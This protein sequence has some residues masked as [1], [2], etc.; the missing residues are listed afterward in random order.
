[1]KGKRR[2]RRRG[3]KGRKENLQSRKI[4]LVE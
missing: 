3:S 1:M 4:N 2:R